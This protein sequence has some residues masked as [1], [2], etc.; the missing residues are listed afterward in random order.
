MIHGTA[1]HTSAFRKTSLTDM[2]R[3]FRW[4]VQAR[5]LTSKSADSACEMEYRFIAPRDGSGEAAELLA[6]DQLGSKWIVNNDS[7]V[8]IPE[9]D[10]VSVIVGCKMP[11]PDCVAV[12]APIERYNEKVQ[13]KRAVRVPD[14][15][16]LAIET[17]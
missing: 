10:L 14:R 13:F 1:A 4:C 12:R 11:E 5:A 17:G 6:A 15:Y 3:Q 2:R 9:G 16:D 8:A 7:M